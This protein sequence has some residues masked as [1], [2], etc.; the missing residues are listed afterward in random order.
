MPVFKRKCFSYHCQNLSNRIMYL[1]Y[2]VA[3]VYGMMRFNMVQEQDNYKS[4]VVVG[5]IRKKSNAY[6]LFPGVEQDEISRLI[7]PSSVVKD[8][9]L[10]NFLNHRVS[11]RLEDDRYFPGYPYRIMSIEKAEIFFPTPKQYLS[12]LEK[13]REI[14]RQLKC[15]RGVV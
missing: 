3:S 5:E 4:V 11:V 8:E 6:E 7:F 2:Y 15:T 14:I 1:V 9:L 10:Q 12:W 13:V